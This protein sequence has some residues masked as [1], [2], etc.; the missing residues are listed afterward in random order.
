LKE[1]S[2]VIADI[3]NHRLSV[4]SA[5]VCGEAGMLAGLIERL[6]GP[7][8]RSNRGDLLND[9]MIYLQ[10]MEQGQT[11]LTRNIRDFSAFLTLAPAS[12]VFFYKT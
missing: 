2:G 3:P 10:A 8:N 7:Q 11:V 4:P 5:Q 1:I 6:R 12:R 9:A